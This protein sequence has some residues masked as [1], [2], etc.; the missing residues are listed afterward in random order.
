MLIPPSIILILYGVVT[1]TSIVALFFALPLGLSVV[2]AFQDKEGN[3]TL[4]NVAKAYELYSTDFVFTVAIVALSSPRIA[5]AVAGTG[6]IVLLV[7][8]LP[9][10]TRMA[11][12][13]TLIQV[14][15]QA[16]DVVAAAF[17]HQDIP[18]DRLIEEL[19]PKV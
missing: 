17:D 1:E 8:A 3:A 14:L 15:H 16:R 18:F 7:V 10:R 5:Y 6:L 4:A 19:A 13:L 12:D 11:R 2:G 9:L